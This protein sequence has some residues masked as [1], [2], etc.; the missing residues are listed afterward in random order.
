MLRYNYLNPRTT[1]QRAFPEVNQIYMHTPEYP[2][3]TF[4]KKKLCTQV[5]LTNALLLSIL[6]SLL[7][8]DK[9]DKYT[10]GEEGGAVAGIV[11]S[12]T[13]LKQGGFC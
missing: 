6:I 7:P 8:I 12:H 2:H 1:T 3:A 9:S 11:Q 4:T 13:K 5:G 10:L